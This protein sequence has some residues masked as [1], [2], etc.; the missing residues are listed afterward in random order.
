MQLSIYL[1]FISE[2]GLRQYCYMASVLF[3]LHTTLLNECWRA[4][5]HC[6]SGEGVI[7]KFKIDGKFFR[8]Y[9]KNA[10]EMDGVFICCQ[11]SALKISLHNK[12]KIQTSLF[13]YLFFAFHNFIF[14]T[15]L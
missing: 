7:V 6:C 1:T 13:I 5:L 3:N 8:R 12:L 2:N 10:D 4:R 11:Y 14:L 9:M 15:A